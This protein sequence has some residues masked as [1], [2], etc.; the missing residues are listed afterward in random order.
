VA[1][2]I[3]LIF[4]LFSNS[5]KKPFIASIFLSPII[6]STWNYK[7]SGISLIDVYFLLF[8]MIFLVRILIRKEKI[9]EIPYQSFFLIYVFILV[10]VS[11]HI[12]LIQDIQT[13]VDFFAKSL[14][15]PLCFYLCFV[16][17][18]KREDG[19]ALIISFI[20]AVIFPLLFI[21]IQKA[22]GYTWRYHTTRG[23]LRS[24]GVYHDVTTARIFIIQAL[25]GIYLYWHYFLDKTRYLAKNFLIVVS[26]LCIIGLYFLYSKAIVLTLILWLLLFSFLRKRIYALP[27]AFGLLILINSILGNRLFYDMKALFSREIEYAA[28]DISSDYVLAGR[29]GLWKMYLKG[30]KDLPVLEKIIGTGIS[31]GGFHNDFLRVLY[32]GGILLLVLYSILIIFFSIKI[33]NYFIKEGKI[34]HFAALLA[35]AYYLAESLGQLPGFYPIIQPFTW[36]L[37]GLSLNRD[38]QWVEK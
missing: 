37:V 24:Q 13:A 27:L 32:S 5:Y 25:I 11:I 6:A 18:S 31:H 28:G 2:L 10:F 16:H 20:L 33:F 21:F 9:Y 29:G 23:L 8:T 36:G 3:L 17:F 38:L 4:S 12:Y 19:K 30:W 7:F 26:I 15:I 14:Y 22:T 1:L 34:I 35:I